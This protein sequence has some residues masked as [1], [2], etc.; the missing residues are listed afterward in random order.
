MRIAPGIQFKVQMRQLILT[1]HCCYY[2]Y[3]Y[4]LI[5]P[6]KNNK[7]IVYYGWGRKTFFL[8]CITNVIIKPFMTSKK[9]AC[10]TQ[11]FKPI[12]G[13]QLKT[14]YAPVEIVLGTPQCEYFL[15][16]RYLLYIY[17]PINCMTKY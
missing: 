5:L 8:I 9:S 12:V 2:H 16:R 14:K 17:V 1:C 3:R 7:S 15:R 10:H 6:L 4:C 11:K 13:L